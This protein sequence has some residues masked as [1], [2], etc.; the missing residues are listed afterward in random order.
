M[1][2]DT[3]SDVNMKAIV[4]VLVGLGVAGAIA[5]VATRDSGVPRDEAAVSEDAVSEDAGEQV[6]AVPEAVEPGGSDDTAPETV[7]LPD[8][9]RFD[10][11]RVAPDGSTVIAGQAPSGAEVSLRLDGEEVGTAQ[12]SG[13][14]D[15]AAILTISP[16][17]Q[18]R[19][20]SLTAI[21]PDGTEV[22]GEDTAIIAPFG[23]AA[24]D[25]PDAPA[26]AE[27]AEDTTPETVPDTT[28]MTAAESTETGPL[29]PSGGATG[30]ADSA[31][32]TDAPT[33]G[34]TVAEVAPDTTAPDTTVPDI[35][36][37][38]TARTD[39]AGTEAAATGG[40]AEAEAEATDRTE[41]AVAP[42]PVPE[43]TASSEAPAA[44]EP[45]SP[46]APEVAAAPP[47]APEPVA[48][49]P[50]A[51]D[52]AEAAEV[53][54]A[55]PEV[56]EPP[57]A[58]SI[59]IASPEGVR[60][61]QDARAPPEALTE[62]Q[63]D[64]ITYTTEGDVALSGRGPADTQVQILLNNR[65]VELGEIG[66]AGQWS[67]ELPD[68]DPGTY[69]LTVAQLSPGGE[70]ESRVD[71]PFLREDP[72]RIV[73]ASPMRVGE[74]VSIITVQPGFTLWGIAEANFG[75]GISYVQI[76]DENRDSIRDPDWIFPGQIFR[77]PDLP[78]GA[79]VE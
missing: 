2:S 55:T 71:T 18:P 1:A 7:A 29:V 74:G 36:V 56:S 26:P 8:P 21:V 76:F 73:A 49:P 51:P 37:P 33:A 60:V 40:P 15:F 5:F 11:I 25:E 17:D 23:R 30:R 46:Q 72:A 34:E 9:P 19:I 63:I 77:L 64:A 12:S 14:G 79:A 22:T 41:A 54:E 45:A 20:M 32:S 31:D 16:S 53:V 68:V 39:I 78:R 43:E 66:P 24:T 50:E 13:A 28:E 61:V 38:D 75:Q 27:I 67:L 69:T 57:E 52:I 6:T 58:P 44:P 35:T 10:Q 47:E 3:A 59:V 65:P 48:T 42:A 4:A 62:V 70:I